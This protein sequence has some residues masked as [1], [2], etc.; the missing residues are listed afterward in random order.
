MTDVDI[1]NMTYIFQIMNN[2][3]DNVPRSSDYNFMCC[4]NDHHRVNTNSTYV[5]ESMSTY[6]PVEEE[7]YTIIF[8]EETDKQ[9]HDN[10]NPA[11]FKL[12]TGSKLSFG[13]L[14][15]SNGE[16]WINGLIAY[17][18]NSIIIRNC[19]YGGQPGF[20]NILSVRN[21]LEIKILKN[22]IIP[23]LIN[24]I[25]KNEINTKSNA[26]EVMNFISTTFKKIYDQKIKLLYDSNF[27]LLNDAIVFNDSI[28]EEILRTTLDKKDIKILELEEINKLMIQQLSH[29][30]EKLDK[31]VLSITQK[32]NNVEEKIDSSSII[33]SSS[34]T[35]NSSSTTDNSSNTTNNF[36]NKSIDNSS[37]KSID[38]SIDKSIHN[39]SDNNIIIDYITANDIIY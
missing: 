24:K 17:N 20:L 23:M 27:T 14:R 25:N 36:S 15:A 12:D 31:N 39:L 22:Y 10:Y 13:Q 11:L 18:K 7:K 34:T 33:D 26:Y 2:N 8:G 4:S 30:E 32:L 29:L 3:D 16:I 28:P 37:D 21:G 35:D 19:D 9:I 1:N 5:S 6:I 38:N